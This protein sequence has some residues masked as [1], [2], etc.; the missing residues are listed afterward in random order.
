MTR[1][2]SFFF[3]EKRLLSIKN[4]QNILYIFF[5]KKSGKTL[6]FYGTAQ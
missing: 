4:Q 6:S 3:C 2:K 5:G 1:K